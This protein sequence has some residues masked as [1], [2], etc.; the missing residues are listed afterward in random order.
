MRFGV[1]GSLEVWSGDQRVSLGGARAESVV[2]T[3][4]LEANHMVPVGR[5]VDAAWLDSPPATAAHQVRKIVSGLRRSLPGGSDMITT[6]SAGYRLLLAPDQLDLSLFDLRLRRAREAEASGQREDVISQLHAALELWRG[7]ALSGLD[8]D[9]LRAAAAALDERRLAAADRLTELRL[10]SGAAR[11]LV[12]DLRSR[13]AAHPLREVTQG[14]LMLALYQAGRQAEAL[15]VYDRTRRLLVDELGIDPG[16]ELARLHELILRSDPSLTVSAAGRPPLVEDIRLELS[17]NSG[18]VRPN[19][20]PYDIPDFVGRT[21]ELAQIHAGVAKSKGQALTIVA[22]DGMPGVG[23]TSVMLHAAHLLADRFPDGQL[24]VDLHGFSPG[25]GPMTPVAALDVLLRGV[26]VPADRIPDDLTAR[27]ALWRAEA[28]GRK[29]L[30]LLDNVFDT[31]QVRPLL[32]GTPGCLVLITSRSRLTGLDGILP[33]F[34][35]PPS[36]E[37]GVRL[38]SLIIGLDRVAREPED[39][40]RLVNMCGGLP[41]AIRILSTR[42]RNRPQWSIRHM[43]ERLRRAERRL[44]ELSV[45]DRSVAA[46]IKLSYDSLPSDQQRMFRLLGMLPGF[47]FDVHTAAAIAGL[48]VERAELLLEGLLDSRL[49]AQ[50]VLA[51]Y[52]LHDI[53]HSFA[54]DIAEAV[55]PER[56]RTGYRC[57]LFDY[58]MRVADAAADVI[59]PGRAR[60]D[61]PY[62][63]PPADVP[64]LANADAAMR[65]F[66]AEY[67]TLLAAI[68]TAETIGLNQHAC[69][70]P[71]ALAYYL[72]LRGRMSELDSALRIA[73]AAARRTGDEMMEGRM[74]INLSI[75]HWHF[76]HLQQALDCAEQA[77]AIAERVG[78]VLNTGVCLGRIGM[79]LNSL[80]Q[81]KEALRFHRRAL[82]VY[83]ET[84][85]RQEQSRTLASVSVAHTALGH[86]HDA[87]RAALKAGAIDR[88]TGDVGSQV[89]SLVNVANARIGLSQLDDALQVLADAVSLART[90]G[91]PNGEA[92]ALA[93]CAEAH[94]RLGQYDEAFDSGCRALQILWA[95]ERPA[96]AAAVE[97]TLG[98]VCQARGEYDLALSRHRQ[99]HALAD[100]AGFRIELARALEG[101]AHALYHLGRK[102]AAAENFQLALKHY[103]EMDVPEAASARRDLETAG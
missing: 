29:L 94:R 68:R 44:F 34:L 27:A 69:H 99:A 35:T 75:P 5:L 76:G 92:V 1:L 2:A 84:G 88:Q 103:D 87:L 65:W 47:E 19:T 66:D 30:V 8:T 62:D 91:S 33:L 9:V 3:L 28:A 31:R 71:R 37:D 14:H 20:L 25:Q 32:P 40:G 60:I 23:K 82:K 93:R 16:P 54:R 26:G 43:V 22:I 61:F 4:L 21:E 63:R 96:I 57:G 50:Q 79:L 101:M 41:L 72:Q 46:A 38:M 6:D 97:N 24:F 17:A 13:S 53:V 58:Y 45:D 100:Q 7:P 102:A 56:S 59:Q 39:A 48:S 10:A 64:R 80:G 55:E 86:Y 67:T 85:P 81:Y 78:D 90:I 36:Q 83:R 73:I 70:L 77:L 89:I 11:E 18:A 49:I 51:R 74:L 52:S 98:L 42:L 12:A 15:E 95:I